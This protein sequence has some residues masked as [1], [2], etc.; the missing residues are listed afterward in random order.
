MD[1]TVLATQLSARVPGGT[2]RYTVELLKALVDT[3]S[4][5]DRLRAVRLPGSAAA[6][7]E[8]DGRRLPVRELPVPFPLLCR[9][10]ARGLPPH[11]AQTGVVHAPTL[12]FPAPRLGTRLVVTIHD[13]VP[14]THPETL[15]P[16]GVSF[17]RTMGA[18][19]AEHAK[20]IVTPTEAVAAV[21]REHLAP[22]GPVIPVLSGAAARPV[23]DDARER[24]RRLGAVTPYVLFVGTAE[25][26]KGLDVLIRAMADSKL[27]GLA[28][29]VAGPTGWGDVSVH[30]LAQVSGI[31]D[32]TLVTGSVSDL[33][34]AA[35]YTGAVALVL[36]SR[37]E[38]FGLPVVEAMVHGVPV[39]T[40]D[41]PALVEVGGGATLATPLGDSDAL[42]AGIQRI[43][44]DTVLRDRLV[45]AGHDRA[46]A[47]TW[48]ATAE[49]MWEVYRQAAGEDARK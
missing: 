43:V 46:R 14:W 36:P 2:G 32:R 40:S 42:A 25:P 44:G 6:V 31:V 45:Q 38:G 37:A 34:L 39:V 16:R 28:L 27:A 10:W 41:D 13:V 9:L 47:L 22:R 26:R 12:L 17:H 4:E 30:A 1:V 48:I 23:P 11:P 19:A 24:R 18:R 35:L 7:A 15:N 29:V 21:V 3:L 5:G 49:R 33:D 20:V 8:L